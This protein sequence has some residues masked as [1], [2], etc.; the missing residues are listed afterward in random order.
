MTR[1]EGAIGTH[2]V[3]IS[4]VL[5]FLVYIVGMSGALWVRSANLQG[6]ADFVALAA[7]DSNA[8][9][10]TAARLAVRD[11]VSLVG[12]QRS[13]AQVRVTVSAASRLPD[14]LLQAGL[15]EDLTAT[16]HAALS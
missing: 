7:V 14:L 1:D 16:S 4:L 12:C 11:G 6:V 13:D 5:S 15:P 2:V 8:G 10:A 3:G 9:C